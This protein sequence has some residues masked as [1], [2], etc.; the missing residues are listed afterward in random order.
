MA[1]AAPIEHAFITAAGRGERMRPL[2]DDRP[3][4]LVE[5]NGQPIIGHV[6]D[7]LVAAGVR[8][9]G[10]NTF[11]RPEPLEDY[12]QQYAV[13]HPG[14]TITIVRESELL[15]TGGGIKNGLGT[16]P[17]APFFV[18]SG[19]SYWEDAPGT[20]TL[21]MMAQTWDSQN[22]DMLLLLKKLDEMHPTR[23]SADYDIDSQGKLTRSLNLTGAYA[24][25]SVRIIKNK[26]I[27][28]N[29]PDTPF[30][31][32]LL[33][34]R[35]QQAGRLYGHILKDDWHHFSTKADVDSVNQ[36]TARPKMSLP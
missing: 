19:D 11:Y 14:L 13:R 21:K 32:R 20:C 5:V 24:W 34:D 15:D 23:G 8:Y 28:N 26:T 18:V 17:N 6:L 10:V 35:A 27:F 9:V 4:P 16:M 30:S 2:T 22:M 31:F 1:L 25:T 36:M 29:T 7:R 3:K 33:M 12:L